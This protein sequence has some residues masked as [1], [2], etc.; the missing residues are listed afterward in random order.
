MGENKPRF[1]HELKYYISYK[2]REALIRRFLPVIKRDI[3]SKEEGYTIRSLYFDDFWNSAYEEKMAGTFARKKYRIRIYDFSDKVIKLECKEKQGSY[4][5]KT[6]VA[7][8]REEFEK[9]TKGEYDF[10]LK[11]EENLCKEFYLE[12]TTKGMRPQ[13]MVDYE[14]E[15]FVVDTGDVR[16]TFDSHVRSG[17]MTNDI[18][19]RSLP[20][21]EVLEPEILIMEVKYT[22]MLP[23]YVRHLVSPKNQIHTAASKYTMCVD[24]KRELTGH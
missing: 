8:L 19:D 17:F 1:R 22:E 9:I 15:A 6:G 7:L 10:L 16:I 12:C 20:T 24:K 18:F 2:E 21:Y 13:V 5:H 4:I 11:R 23:E 14:R 3:H